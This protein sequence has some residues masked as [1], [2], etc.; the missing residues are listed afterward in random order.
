MRDRLTLLHEWLYRLFDS[1]NYRL[2]PASEDA[3][4]RRYYRVSV[5][6]QTFIVM[7]APPEHE[8]IEAFVR[9]THRL[10][11]HVNVPAIHQSD[12]TRGFLLLTDLGSRRYLENLN[13]KT[14]GTLYQD[15]IN[16]LARMQIA[17]P[18]ADLEAY[19]ET[20]LQTEMDLFNDWLLKRHLGVDLASGEA[21][22]LEKIQAQLILNALEQP[23]VFVHRDY[24]SRN[25]MQT[26]TANPGVL[27]YQG[28]V[29]GP[30]AYDL[31]SL[32]KD[33]YIKWPEREINRWLNDY[34]TQL[35][36]GRPAWAPD[37]DRFKRWF[38][39]MGVQRHLKASGLFARLSRRD[40]KHG[41]LGDIP[42]TL[43]YI[44]DLKPAY[45]E[46]APLCRIIETR[47]LPGLG[48]P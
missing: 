38:D 20:R 27:D 42:R 23:R 46:L 44:I 31:V 9:I 16:A 28:A 4:F 48:R 45:P 24:H 17:A 36:N 34:L 10:A 39:L 2:A 33:C 19:N 21:E 18:A 26:R 43:S 5:A 15:A 29:Q 12:M 35:K 8:D 13:A 40:G 6:D 32:L 22:A 1:D 30:L 25:L 11:A 14:A 3:S 47:I 7:D 41:F 37:K